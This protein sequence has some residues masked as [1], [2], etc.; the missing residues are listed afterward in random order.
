MLVRK[1]FIE[2]EEDL[3]KISVSE[4][5]QLV[6]VMQSVLGD[7]S[8]QMA[9]RKRVGENIVQLLS[10]KDKQDVLL[11]LAKTLMTDTKDTLLALF[12]VENVCEYSFDEDVLKTHTSE[13]CSI[14]EACLGHAD[15]S[16]RVG[17][18][19]CV[20]VYLRVVQQESQASKF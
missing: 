1:L 10:L 5:E 19:K 13:L 6:Q 14:F 12:L 2:K 20:G 4:Q 16:V 17:A 8:R 7:A 3:Q 9:V 18:V 15:L 11:Q